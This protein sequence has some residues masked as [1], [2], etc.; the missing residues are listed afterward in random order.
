MDPEV[1]G[2]TVTL[3]TLALSG[4]AVLIAALAPP[5]RA[6]EG[7]IRPFTAVYA[8]DWHGLPAGYSTLSL[9]ESDPG[10]YVYSSVSRARGLFRLAFPE[11]LSE[12]STFRIANGRIEPL[13]YREDNGRDRRKNDVTLQFDWGAMRVT[14]EAGG[15]TVDQPLAPGTVDPL[16]VQIALM[17]KLA[18]G[19]QP[20]H[21]L[22]FDKTEAAQYRYT[23]EGSTAIDTAFG[24]LETVVYRSDRPD[25]DRVMR[26]WLAPS[27]GYLPVRAERRRRGSVEFQL[28][29]RELRPTP[30]GRPAS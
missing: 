30:A 10:R 18:A 17:R 14:G 24:P 26:F 1:H 16:S 28:Q 3:R 12:C 4:L 2:M 20:T 11:P 25:S 13:V 27:L 15:K 5:S 29:I 23:R 6:A 22:L 21:F 8:L 9:A 19:E 7:A